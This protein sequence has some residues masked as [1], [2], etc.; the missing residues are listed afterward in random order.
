MTHRFVN[1][2]CPKCGGIHE[3]VAGMYNA[4]GE[5][6][7]QRHCRDCHYTDVT[8]EDAGTSRS[9]ILPEPPLPDT[10]T[11]EPYPEDYF[12]E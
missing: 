12:N 9:G 3:A 5:Y 6:L 4:W 10:P 8:N 11:H 2:T 7:V 1:K